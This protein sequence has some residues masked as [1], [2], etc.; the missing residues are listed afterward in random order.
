MCWTVGNQYPTSLKS[1]PYE[2][3]R[4]VKIIVNTAVTEVTDQFHELQR[5]RRDL[6]QEVKTVEE[7]MRKLS[8]SLLKTNN[9]QDFAI[10]SADGYYKVCEIDQVEAQHDIPKMVDMLLKLRRK[11][12]FKSKTSIVIRWLSEEEQELVQGE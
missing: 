11:I 5:K 8:Q 1:T 9:G 10:A 4:L 3:E 6:M 12:P 7:A 2:T